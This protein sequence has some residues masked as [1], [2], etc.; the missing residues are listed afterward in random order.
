MLKAEQGF[1]DEV[2]TEVWIAKFV[3]NHHSHKNKE[4][5]LK[6]KRKGKRFLYF[7]DYAIIRAS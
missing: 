2:C 6:E 4:R 3:H 1:L 5:I 7:Y